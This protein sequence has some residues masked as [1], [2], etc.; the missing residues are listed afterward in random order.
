MIK[1]QVS[2]MPV[3]TIM[4]PLESAAVRVSTTIYCSKHYNVV[5]YI[6]IIKNRFK[7]IYPVDMAGFF[8]ITYTSYSISSHIDLIPSVY[9]LNPHV[10]RR[11]SSHA[12]QLCSRKCLHCKGKGPQVSARQSL[13]RIWRFFAVFLQNMVL[14]FTRSWV[15]G[16]FRVYWVSKLKCIISSNLRAEGS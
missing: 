11:I 6:F 7:S 2:T 13:R 10:S 1:C 15:F 14:N 3:S 8:Y 9:R 16:I 12:S 4:I 5:S